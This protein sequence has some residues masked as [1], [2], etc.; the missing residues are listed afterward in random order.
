ML[1]VAKH[2]TSFKVRKREKTYFAHDLSN[3]TKT[4]TKFK[5]AATTSTREFICLRTTFARILAIGL[6]VVVVV[7]A[8][9]PE[10]VPQKATLLLTSCHVSEL[11]ANFAA[12]FCCLK[13]S[14]TNK[15]QTF[16]FVSQ[17]VRFER[18]ELGRA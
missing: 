18:R 14:C 17:V 13:S 1:V 9:E 7:V 10:M 8:V 6:L 15:R 3:V 2:V 4:K 5:A 11:K 16:H 12:K